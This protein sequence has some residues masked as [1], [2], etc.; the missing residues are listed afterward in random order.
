MT[1]AGNVILTVAPNGARKTHSDHA[2]LPITPTELAATA[3]ACRD[4]GAA[5]IH[6][7]VR[8]DDGRHSLDPGRY[9]AA[10][11]AIRADLGDDIVIQATTEG[12]GIYGP[13]EQMQ[14]IRDLQ[15]EAASFGL[16][17]FIPDDT[18]TRAVETYQQFLTWAQGA[19]IMVQHILYDV[20]D[21]ERFRRLSV[22]GVFG[23]AP[24][25]VLY[26][27]GRYSEGQQ[28]DPSEIQ[29][30]LDAADGLDVQ[31][32]VCAF[33]AQEA[34]CAARAI[35]LGGHARVGFENNMLLA[36]GSQAPDNAALVAQA[37]R[38]AGNAGR[39]L[40]DADIARHIM[41]RGMV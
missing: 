6:L 28:S 26:V 40:A 21:V 41:S 35:E 31:W 20:S 34:A 15:P 13:A 32:T 23:D 12:V 30:F 38:A 7:H 5:M 9:R 17:E 8:E 10:I 33:G 11:S 18:D 14:C 4:A 19:G 24:W 36:D 29:P 1:D 37:A 25:S 27:L 3:R 16:R 22:Q 39:G 2:A